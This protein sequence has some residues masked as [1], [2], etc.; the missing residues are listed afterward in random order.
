MVETTTK[1]TWLGHNCFQLERDGLRFLVDPFIVEGL[2][3]CRADE[4]ETDYILVSQGHADHCQ[5][6]ISI[7]KRTGATVVSIA[8]MT[9][10]FGRNG[11]KTEP[12]NIGGAIYLPTHATRSPSVQVL[13]VQ[14]P[15]SSTTPSGEPGG[16]SLGFVLSF[17]QNGRDLSPSSDSL[18]PMKEALADADAFNVYFVCD[19]GYFS[20][21]AWIGELGIDLAVV[22]IGDRY[23]MGARVS[24]DAISLLSPK[25]VAPSHYN[26]WPPLRQ[27]VDAW[28]QSVK[29]YTN[30]T[31]LELKPGQTVYYNDDSKTWR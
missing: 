16:N 30:A 28:R 19:A 4:I 17:S 24:L 1:L 6:A 15:H 13:A 29:R 21:L 23:T 25:Y 22:P 9:S 5:D 20:E 2:A 8:E 3:P 10:Y 26:T 12:M 18:K 31:P 7:G 27:N 11:L 14:A